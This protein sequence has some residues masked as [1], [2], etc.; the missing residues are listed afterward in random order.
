MWAIQTEQE[1]HKQGR[2]HRLSQE[3]GHKEQ[4]WNYSGVVSNTNTIFTC[5]I[6][7][8]ALFK[9]QR[10]SGEK[11]CMR[12]NIYIYMYTQRHQHFHTSF[13]HFPHKKQSDEGK[14]QLLF[15]KVPIFIMELAE[16]PQLRLGFKETDFT[17]FDPTHP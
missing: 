13:V 10:K 5:L 16:K 15:P 6:W 8:L 1:H 3:S 9:H 4:A 7:N 17:L 12:L 14:A 11:P 2:K